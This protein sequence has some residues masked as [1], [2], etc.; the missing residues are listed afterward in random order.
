MPIRRHHLAN[1]DITT[2]KIRVGEVK[3]A[4]IGDAQVTTAKITDL[5]VITGKLADAAVNRAKTS[6]VFIQTGTVTVSFAFAVAGVE[7]ISGVVTFAT[8]FPTGVIPI[9]FAA[10]N[11]VD[12]HTTGVTAISETG[13]TLTLS[14]TAGVDKTA[15]VS[16]VVAY[17]A[18]AP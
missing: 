12:L 13:F 11:Q 17:L 9:V 6:S 2:E 10:I 1:E 15:A 16:V 8:A 14:D 18:I 4:D 3:T 7:R 5:N